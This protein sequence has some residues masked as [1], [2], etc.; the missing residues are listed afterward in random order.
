[1]SYQFN[2]IV[3]ILFFI[4]IYSI[5]KNVTM[6]FEPKFHIAFFFIIHPIY[7]I[8]FYIFRN[9]NY[10]HNNEKSIMYIVK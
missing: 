10:V 3:T 2:E 5:Q 9:N 7:E 8:N 4:N 1:M 6:E